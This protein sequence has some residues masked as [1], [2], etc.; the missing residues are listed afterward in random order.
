MPSDPDATLRVPQPQHPSLAPL[1]W[2]GEAQKSGGGLGLGAAWGFIED[3]AEWFVRGSTKTAGVVGFS[4]LS[5]VR[6]ALWGLLLLATAA[7]C[8]YAGIWFGRVYGP[9]LWGAPPIDE[10]VVPPV[11]T[12]SNSPEAAQQSVRELV[13]GFYASINDHEYQRAYEALSP[14]WQKE[15]SFDTFKNGYK[16]TQAARCSVKGV[17]SLPGGRYQMDIGL[18]V[19]EK[20]R[21]RYFQG[22]YVAISTVGGWKLDQGS[23]R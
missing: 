12:L 1:G 19:K 8:V 17:R 6:L 10:P 11:R 16:D 13:V 21:T 9:R 2:E 5:G 23:I 4:V 3:F 22:T 7:S 14:A 15:M 18:E 20:G